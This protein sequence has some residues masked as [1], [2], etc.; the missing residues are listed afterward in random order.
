MNFLNRG[1]YGDFDYTSPRKMSQY[2][3]QKT[4]NAWSCLPT[5]F[6]M[7]MDVPLQSVL[8]FVG[9]DGSEI[10][11]AGLPDPVCRK[12]FHPQE[13][14]RYCLD[15]GFA[16]T[17][18]ELASQATPGNAYAATMFDFGWEDFFS[19]LKTEG[20]VLDT[21]TSIGLGHAM[22][23]EGHIDHVKVYDPATGKSFELREAEDA[24]R[25]GRFI[26]AAWLINR[27]E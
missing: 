4:P 18:L 27:I 11:R 20:G 7:A 26:Y 2:A 23:F 14:I 19:Y 1:K 3:S 21:R 25:Q 22:A 10:V 6:A 12:G 13:V 16:V 9:H 15:Q 24:K 8:D 17:R 5:A